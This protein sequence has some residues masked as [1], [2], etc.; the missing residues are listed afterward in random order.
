MCYNLNISEKSEFEAIE[1]IVTLTEISAVETV[2]CQGEAIEDSVMP[3]N[4]MFAQEKK[5]ENEGECCY[6]V[7]EEVESAELQAATAEEIMPMDLTEVSKIEDVEA[8]DLQGEKIEEIV[9]PAEVL[10]VNRATL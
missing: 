5:A 2:A 9:A 6:D 1:E 4:E 10:T 3:E 8:A 7:E